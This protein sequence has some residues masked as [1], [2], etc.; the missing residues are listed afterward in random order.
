VSCRAFRAV[1]VLKSPSH[2]F[3]PLHRTYEKRGNRGCPHNRYFDTLPRPQRRGWIRVRNLDHS[4][5]C[6]PQIMSN[7]LRRCV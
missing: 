6:L 4:Q 5:R 7:Y 3:T 1:S 2:H